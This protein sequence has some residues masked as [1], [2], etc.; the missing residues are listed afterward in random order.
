MK[1]NLE[2]GLTLALIGATSTMIGLILLGFL[3]SLLNKIFSTQKNT[4]PDRV[5]SRAGNPSKKN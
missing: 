5:S 1:E 2:F 3:S 4:P